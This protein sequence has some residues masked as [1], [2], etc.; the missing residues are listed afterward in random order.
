MSPATR[1]AGVILLAAPWARAFYLPGSA[2]RDYSFN[3]KVDVFVNALTPVI[4]PQAKL[5]R[6][7]HSSY[8]RFN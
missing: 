5:V 4:G 2:P 6:G 3:E 1:L 8:T 7:T